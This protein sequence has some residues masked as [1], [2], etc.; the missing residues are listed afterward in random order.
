MNC[1]WYIVFAEAVVIYVL[2]VVLKDRNV[3]LKDQEEEFN[4]ILKEYYDKETDKETDK[5]CSKRK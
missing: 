4:E 2:W 3:A 5:G 1:I